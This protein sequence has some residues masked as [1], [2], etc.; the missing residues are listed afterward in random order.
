MVGRLQTVLYIV[1]IAGLCRADFIVIVDN[2]QS[3]M[4]DDWESVGRMLRLLVL[5]I[6]SYSEFRR[7]S[8]IGFIRFNDNTYEHLRNHHNFDIDGV[9]RVVNDIKSKRP[10]GDTMMLEPVQ[11]AVRRLDEV[12]EER[13]P[14]SSAAQCII[15]FTDGIPTR[16]QDRD[17]V[18]QLFKDQMD[19][20]VYVVL[21]GKS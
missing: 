1:F 7:F 21:I 14:R 2:S 10:Y 15:M 11:L 19:L 13:G 9:I 3:I 12:R 20:G 8:T 16:S 18:I 4:T 6:D 17:D 5:A